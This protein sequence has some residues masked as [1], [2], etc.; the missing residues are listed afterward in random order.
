MWLCEIRVDLQT[1]HTDVKYVITWIDAIILLI[2]KIMKLTTTNMKLTTKFSLSSYLD[3]STQLETHD[4]AVCP[5]IM[6]RYHHHINVK[7][8]WINAPPSSPNSGP[9]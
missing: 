1:M 2:I 7:Y 4:H 8:G 6:C 3:R 5:L 9:L